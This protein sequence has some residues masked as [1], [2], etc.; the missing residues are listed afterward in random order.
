MYHCA[1]LTSLPVQGNHLK[2]GLLLGALSS[3]RLPDSTP[4]LCKLIG[5]AL[6]P[7]SV[8]CLEC[9]SAFG[10]ATSTVHRGRRTWA[11]PNDWRQGC[12]T[13]PP[14][15]VPIFVNYLLLFSGALHAAILRV[16]GANTNSNLF[17]SAPFYA[18]LHQGHA[19]GNSWSPHNN[20][21][22]SLM[23]LTNAW[24]VL[25]MHM[26]TNERET[27]TRFHFGQARA[28]R[29]SSKRQLTV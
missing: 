2:L 24:H 13:P 4:A 23:G 7:L 5:M 20:F 14:D 22:N 10:P 19:N 21:D 9:A 17:A 27:G 1:S 8:L 11:P 29:L 25:P 16:S 18:P 12:T 26:R 15:T 3:V 6:R 28:P